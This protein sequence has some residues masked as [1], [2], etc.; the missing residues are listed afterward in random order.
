MIAVVAVAAVG[1]LL[2]HL[3]TDTAVK[4]REVAATPML[5]L[6]PPPPPEKPPEP[7]PEKVQPEEPEPKPTPEKPLEQT[8]EEA[9][10]NPSQ[11]MNPVTIAGD[12][13]AG[14]DAYGAL[15]GDGGGANGTGMPRGG[16]GNGSY[17]AYVSSSLQRELARDDRTKTLAFDDIRLDV[18]LDS[19]GRTTRAELVKGTG[20]KEID[21]AVLAMVQEFRCDE[22]PPPGMPFPLHMTVRGR[23]P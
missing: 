18:W 5:M 21:A 10:P 19:E 6:P 4:R 23:R 15:S 12:A 1:A 7:E 20:R 3:L 14:T 9:P 8:K 13:Q 2:W 22:R 11:D 16:P 17:G